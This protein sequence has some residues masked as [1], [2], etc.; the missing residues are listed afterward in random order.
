MKIRHCYAVSQVS[1][2][3][4][5]DT[6]FVSAF[7]TSSNCLKKYL[8]TEEIINV[9]SLAAR[10]KI[11]LDIICAL[12]VEYLRHMAANTSTTSYH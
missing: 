12:A 6:T 2:C 3:I 11:I 4:K 5:L 7:H 10:Q 9:S 1:T 8:F